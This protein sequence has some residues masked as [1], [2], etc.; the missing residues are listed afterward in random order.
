MCGLYTREINLKAYFLYSQHYVSVLT[1][2]SFPN[3]LFL[4]QGF[5]CCFFLGF[6]NPV[7]HIVSSPVFQKKRKILS[8]PHQCLEQILPYFLTILLVLRIWMGL[9]ILL[10][11]PKLG[12]D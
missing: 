5:L 9:T 12:Y 7:N 11:L 4:W 8:T 3:H 2:A 6:Q 10:R 1:L